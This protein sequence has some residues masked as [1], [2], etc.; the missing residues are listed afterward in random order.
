MTPLNSF[1]VKPF[2]WLFLYNFSDLFGE[3]GLTQEDLSTLD[4]DYNCRSGRKVASGF[5]IL[6]MKQLDFPQKFSSII[7]AKYKRK[8]KGLYDS[9]N[10]EYDP[11]SPYSMEVKDELTLEKT[12]EGSGSTQHT[13]E[14]ERTVNGTNKVDGTKSSNTSKDLT[15]TDQKE[16][17]TSTNSS[18]NRDTSKDESVYGFNSDTAVPNS[19]TEEVVDEG[20]QSSGSSDEATSRSEDETA[21]ETVTDDTTTTINNTDT[22]NGSAS[23]EDVSRGSE[24][25]DSLRTI[26]RKGNIGNQ[27]YQ[28]IIK[29]QRDLVMFNIIEVMY[30][31]IDSVLTRSRYVEY[32]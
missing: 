5:T 24:S 9:M 32:L 13:S 25:E 28:E 7:S 6:G 22:Q 10:L 31:D 17:T 16:T 8:W 27:T 12:V 4:F 20:V 14:N 2:Q 30:D 23:V 15:V 18:T 3:M 29:Q 1:D 11:L 26:T 19:K 21:T